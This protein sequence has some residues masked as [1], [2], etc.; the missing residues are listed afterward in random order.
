[1]MMLLMTSEG[2]LAEDLWRTCGCTTCRYRTRMI[3]NVN[4]AERVECRVCD[5]ECCV[6]DAESTDAIVAWPLTGKLRTI[7]E[8]LEINNTI[9]DMGK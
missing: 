4:D 7:R 5:A 9:V 3:Q 2:E 6:V 8:V 1:M